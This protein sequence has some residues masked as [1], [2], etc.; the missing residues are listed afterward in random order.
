MERSIRLDHVDAFTLREILASDDATVIIPVGSLEQH[1]PHLPL[2]TDTLL[3][4]HVAE[5]VARI[6]PSTLVAPAIVYGYKSQQKSGGGNHLTGT[7]SLEGAHLSAIARDLT[8]AY[9]RQGFTNI[10]YLNGHFENYQFLYEGVDIA[11]DELGITAASS[12]TRGRAILLSYWDFV[13]DATLS[14]V[15]SAGGFPG[16]DVEHG[17][18]LETSLMLH[19]E[20][21]K[22]WME[23]AVDHPP[24]SFPRFD[25]LPVVAE[26]TPDTGCLSSPVGSTAEKGKLLYD[27]VTDSIAQDLTAELSN[28]H[29]PDVTDT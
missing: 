20:P 2:G 15:Y 13:S 14:D 12:S 6:A 4:T 22:V 23:A 21:D 11:L 28:H 24:A 17:G 1:G 16:W 19:R 5:G 29:E 3:S 27:Q 9:L 7:V 26:R 8:R 10:V 18:V 25:R